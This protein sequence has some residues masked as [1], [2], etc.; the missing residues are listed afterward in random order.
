M[1]IM[2]VISVADLAGD[3]LLT[4]ILSIAFDFSENKLQNRLLAPHSRNRVGDSL[5][6]NTGFSPEHR[7][8]NTIILEKLGHRFR[9]KTD[10]TIV[11]CFYFHT[12]KV[13]YPL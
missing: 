5:Y 3:V 1:E 10:V 8:E 2:N 11:C 13:H 9:P 4:K 6:R 12:Q 7:V